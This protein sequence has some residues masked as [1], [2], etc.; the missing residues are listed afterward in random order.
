VPLYTAKPVRFVPR[1]LSAKD[2]VDGLLYFS[3]MAWN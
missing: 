3:G 2:R 1:R